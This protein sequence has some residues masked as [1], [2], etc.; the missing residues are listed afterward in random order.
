MRR[1]VPE[2]PWLSAVQCTTR[3]RSVSS[4]RLVKSGAADRAGRGGAVEAAVEPPIRGEARCA[5]RSGRHNVDWIHAT[6][7]VTSPAPTATPYRCGQKSY[8]VSQHPVKDIPLPSGPAGLGGHRPGPG[9]EGRGDWKSLAR[10]SVAMDDPIGISAG[11]RCEC[12]A[13]M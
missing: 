13:D 3:I 9:D 12:V 8:P 4:D 5:L 7:G 2:Y 10:G 1:P 11:R 6:T